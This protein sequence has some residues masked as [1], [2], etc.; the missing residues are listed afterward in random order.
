MAPLTPATLRAGIDAE[1]RVQR[2]PIIVRILERID[3]PGDRV[4][5]QVRFQEG[6]RQGDVPLNLDESLEGA[7]IRE[8]HE[9]RWHGRIEAF[10]PIRRSLVI[11]LNGRDLPAPGDTGRI[12]PYGYLRRLLAWAEELEELPRPLVELHHRVKPSGPQRRLRAPARLRQT[13]RKAVRL[14]GG[15]LLLVWGPPGT[16]KTHTLAAIVERHVAQG[17]RV[18]AVSTSNV[19]VDLLVL[20]IDD[21]FRW[22]GRH[23]KPGE[24]VR[25]GT[26]VNRELK[27]DPSRAH[28]LRWTAALSELASRERDLIRF[29]DQLRAAIGRLDNHSPQRRTMLSHLAE[30]SE[31]IRDLSHTRNEILKRLAADARIVVTT[32]T[33]YINNSMLHEKEYEVTVV[34]EASMVPAAIACR[35]LADPREAWVF[36]GD[37]MQLPPV[38]LAASR[39]GRVRTWIA[40]SLFEVAGA[41]E[42]GERAHLL[43]RGTMV[44]LDEQ[45]RMRP[46]IAEVISDTFYDGRLKTIDA[47]APLAGGKGWP[48]DEVVLVDPLAYRLPEGAPPLS[49]RPVAV[50]PTGHTWDRSAH[51][52]RDL[53]E[54]ALEKFGDARIVVAAPY[55]QQA[56]LLERL[57]APLDDRGRVLVGTVHRMQGSEADIVVFDPVDPLGWFLTASPSSPRLVNVALSRARRQVLVLGRR[58]ELRQNPWLAGVAEAAA[59]W[60]GPHRA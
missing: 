24:L 3:L 55:R 17:R 49:P 13:Q 18:L 57:V 36:G 45:S 34:D 32:C 1:L 31:Q 50:R 43:E 35:L 60:N 20:A 14:A 4:E 58:D 9:R 41:D 46:A 7:E 27:N 59:D 29:R 54:H 40:R 38:S 53:V 21:A 8:L 5:L 6:Q 44:M 30:V 10:E 39:D 15:P 25:P 51:V 19:A 56:S 33:S 16:G 28:L 12:S 48:S 2:R 52:V 26:P 37:F 23:M 22:A 47:P 11:K 42:A